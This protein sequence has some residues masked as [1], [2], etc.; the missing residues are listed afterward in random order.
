MVRSTAS[1][2]MVTWTPV[3]RLTNTND[4]LNK[5]ARFVDLMG[6]GGGLP[7]HGIVGMQTPL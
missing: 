1:L 2:V 5:Y 4:C 6:G 7:I 3:D